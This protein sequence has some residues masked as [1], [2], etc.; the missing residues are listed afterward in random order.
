M[1]QANSLCT[2]MASNLHLS[3]NRGNPIIND[4]QYRSI[5]G[6]LQ[7]VTITRP[8]ITYSV[9]KVSQ[10]MH[11][12]LDEY[13]EAVKRILR[14]LKGTTNQGLTLQSCKTLNINGYADADWATDYD[15]RKSTSG[16]CIFLG[17]NPISWCSKKQPTV[18]RSST[19]AEYKSVASATAEIMWI[20]SLL[21]ELKVKTSSK[22]T[23]WCDNLSA[24]L[25]AANSVL[26]SRTKHMKLD[27][28]FV[29]IS[30][31]NKL[32]KKN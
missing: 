29:R 16:Y 19:E 5:V 22:A 25:L 12:P 21:S 20:E 14:Y 9:N 10:F 32:R 17:K 7:Y 27:L 24:T 28:Y 13:L 3:K 23:I 26:H 2:P 31:E 15:D 30:L 18:S 4:K 8:E 6:A 11:K 1:L